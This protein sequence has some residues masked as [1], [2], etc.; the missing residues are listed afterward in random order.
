MTR[1]ETVH[2][3]VATPREVPPELLEPLRAKRPAFTAL[4]DYCL[5][6]DAW[7]ELLAAIG[8]LEHYYHTCRG[9]AAPPP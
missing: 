8:E 9:F 4:G 3:P 5:T 1:T 2:I 7:L 6:Y